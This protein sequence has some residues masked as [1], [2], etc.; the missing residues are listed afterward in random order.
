MFRLFKGELICPV[1]FQNGNG[2]YS[3]ADISVAALNLSNSLFSSVQNY[4]SAPDQT[5]SSVNSALSHLLE[6]YVF[7]IRLL[8]CSIYLQSQI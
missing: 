1:E 3:N 6:S 5:V 2:G 4:F 7:I 8:H